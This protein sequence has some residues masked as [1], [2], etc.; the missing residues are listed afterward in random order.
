MKRKIIV[1]L[2][3]A[4]VLFPILKNFRM[5][6]DVVILGNEMPYHLAMSYWVYM[7]IHIAEN[8]LFLPMAYLILVLIPYNMIL[9]RNPIDSQLLYRKVWVKILVL[10]GNHLLLI[11]LLGTFA[12]IWAVP[13]WQNVYYVGF[14]L[15]YSIIPASIIHFAVDRREIREREGLIW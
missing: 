8:F 2:L 4:F 6:F 13:Y 3:M 11:C 12:N 15:L 14:A 7:K 10:T 9:I 5:F 1:N